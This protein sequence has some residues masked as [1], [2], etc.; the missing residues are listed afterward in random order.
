MLP[1]SDGGWERSYSESAL[2][3]CYYCNLRTVSFV[4]SANTLVPQAVTLEFEAVPTM[5]WVLFPKPP[6]LAK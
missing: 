5:G 6:T 1:W 4:A 2:S 3:N